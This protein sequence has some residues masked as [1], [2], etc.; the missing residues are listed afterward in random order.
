VLAKA[1]NASL[2]ALIYSL[3]IAGQALRKASPATD[4]ELPQEDAHFP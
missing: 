3:Q 4:F 1:F 2:T